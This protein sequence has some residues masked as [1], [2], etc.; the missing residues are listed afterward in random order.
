MGGLPGD[1]AASA[2]SMV[3]LIN[4]I[5]QKLNNPSVGLFGGTSS[6]AQDYYALMGKIKNNA[7]YEERFKKAE[8]LAV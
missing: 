1:I 6:I 7:F 3:S 5:E 8:E 2:N 4:S